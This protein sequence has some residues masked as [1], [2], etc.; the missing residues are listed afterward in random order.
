M[1]TSKSI[2]ILATPRALVLSLCSANFILLSGCA[3]VTKGTS[4]SILI[5]V[6]PSLA[7][8]VLGRKVGGGL[9]R[10]SI[11]RSWVKVKKA[12]TLLVIGKAVISP[13]GAGQQA[14]DQLSDN[15]KILNKLFIRAFLKR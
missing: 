8:C 14:P 4:Q 6:F 9:S 3:S 7:S 11:S 2:S 13:A 12:T 1:T 10:F 15:G 5:E